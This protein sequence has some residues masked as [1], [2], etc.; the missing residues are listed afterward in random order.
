MLLKNRPLNLRD[1]KLSY[2][3][4]YRQE[5]WRY[6]Q[7]QPCCTESSTFL[8]IASWL[9]EGCHIL[10]ML[11]HDMQSRAAEGFI[12]ANAVSLHDNRR[13]TQ[14]PPPIKTSSS[15]LGQSEMPYPGDLETFKGLSGHRQSKASPSGSNGLHLGLANSEQEVVWLDSEGQEVQ[16]PPSPSCYCNCNSQPPSSFLL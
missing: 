10:H 7:A 9:I 2:S 12:S 13:Q 8:V 15:T 6:I 11:L 5:L 1:V 3:S 4:D 14:G 16:P